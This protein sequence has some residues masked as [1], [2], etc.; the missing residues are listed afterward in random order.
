[1]KITVV[2]NPLSGKRRAPLVVDHAHRLATS[3]GHEL[4]VRTINSSGDGERFTREAIAHG[5]DRVIAVGGDGTLNAVAGGLIDTKVPLGVVAMGSGNGYARSLGLSLKPE[6]ALAHAFTAPA[7]AVDICYL[8]DR[9]FLGTA[10]IGFD[11]RVAYDF[12]RS[13]GRGLWTYMRIILKEILGAQPMR[14][15]VKANQE[16]SESQVLMLV[17]CNSREFGNGAIISPRS[18]PDDGM[19]ELQLVAKPPLP[20]LVKAFFDVYTGRADRSKH[21]R[22]IPCR[23]AQV[24]QDGLLAHLDGEPVEIGKEIRFRLERERLWVVG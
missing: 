10:G 8:N 17:F 24:H 1:M 13:A 2:V 3:D 12:D 15:V 22:S 11:A 16:T 7:R 5:A 9:H 23:E 20:A 6:V 19:A 14:V 18:V 4:T 21:I